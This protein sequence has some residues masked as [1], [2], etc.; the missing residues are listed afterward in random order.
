MQMLLRRSAK[1]YSVLYESAGLRLLW[2]CEP[3]G[4]G[5]SCVGDGPD[6]VESHGQFFYA[7]S[8]ASLM[9]RAVVH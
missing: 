7:S 8:A 3:A 5:L 4:C 2:V 9:R 1:T 6:K